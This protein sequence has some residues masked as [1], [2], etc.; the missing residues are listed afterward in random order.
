MLFFS[1][2]H[3]DILFQNTLYLSENKKYVTIWLFFSSVFSKKCN[4]KYFYNYKKTFLNRWHGMELFSDTSR[5]GNTH[6]QPSMEGG[7]TCNGLYVGHNIHRYMWNVLLSY[8]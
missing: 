1:F 5:C 8:V 6:I 7:H 3:Y 4:S 2:Y